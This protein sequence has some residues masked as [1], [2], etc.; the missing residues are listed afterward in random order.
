MRCQDLMVVF[1][2]IA[3]G[4]VAPQNVLITEVKNLGLDVPS[5]MA[6]NLPCTYT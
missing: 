4:L 6:T 5:K 2:S 1:K 3:T